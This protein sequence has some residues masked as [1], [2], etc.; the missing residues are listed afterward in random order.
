MVGRNMSKIYFIQYNT[1]HILE[2]VEKTALSQVQQILEGRSTRTFI[3]RTCGLHTVVIMSLKQN[4]FWTSIGNY[5][6]L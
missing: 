3:P 4:R 5:V 1:L 6:L 2:F